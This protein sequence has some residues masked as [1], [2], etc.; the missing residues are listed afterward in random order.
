MSKYSRITYI[1]VNCKVNLYIVGIWHYYSAST[2]QVMGIKY[3]PKKTSGFHYRYLHRMTPTISYRQKVK[4]QIRTLLTSKG[5]YLG[6]IYFFKKCHKN[7]TT[8]STTTTT[9]LIIPW[10]LV[11][12][13]RGKNDKLWLNTIFHPWIFSALW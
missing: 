10:P 8:T 3:W 13:T 7:V 5:Q 12:P 2:W 1:F 4:V 9:T 11:I 6:L